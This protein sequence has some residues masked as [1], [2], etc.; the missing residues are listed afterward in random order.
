MFSFSLTMSVLRIPSHAGLVFFL[1]AATGI[2]GQ[3]ANQQQHLSSSDVQLLAQTTKQ[4]AY[5]Y[6]LAE[7]CTSKNRNGIQQYAAALGGWWARN[8]WK[9]LEAGPVKTELAPGEYDGLKAEATKE[10]NAHSFKSVFACG[11]IANVLKQP[12]H[13]PS[14]KYA[15]DLGRIAA[16]SAPAN[17]QQ[18][19]TPD[20]GAKASSN[21]SASATQNP[22]S[23]PP[24]NA[25]AGETSA[26]APPATQSSAP[27]QAQAPVI[28]NGSPLIV[29]D[30]SIT[31]T[32]GWSVSKSTPDQVTLQKTM[33]TKL[34]SSTGD[35]RLVV[36]L[37]MQPMQGGLDQSFAAA[38]RRNFPGP[39]LEL[40]YINKGVTRGGQQARVVRDGG[41]M[42]LPGN[43]R[44]RIRAVGIAAPDG[45]MLL[46]MIL[47]RSDWESLMSK[48]DDEFEAMIASLRFSSQPEST[49]WSF[50]RPQKGGG[51]QSGLYWANALI[52]MPNAFGGMDLRAERYY[53]ILM[54]DGRAYNDLPEDGHVQD[55]DINAACQKKPKKCGTY[56]ISGGSIQ[57]KWY[58]DYGLVE[59][60]QS[61]W[62]QGEKGSFN[63]RGHDY[64]RI[65]PVHGLRVNGKYTSTFASVGS[66]GT[67][68]TSVVSEKYITFT[69]D[70]RYQKSGFS[71][72][73]FD[74]SN[75]AGTFTSRKGVQAGTYSI[76]GYTLTLTPTGSAPELYS[77]IFED[78]TPSPKAI[79]INDDGFL[80]N[81]S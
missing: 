37:S 60:S 29:G 43:P 66:I 74:N 25:A 36:L 23:Q 19:A 22:S 50:D 58:D 31:P 38:V 72:G 57:F 16:A 13:D 61:P 49:L 70:G 65:L 11:A 27:H 75:A 30:A 46:A 6:S 64:R 45:R 44:A 56:Q 24:A 51:G 73:S 41:R 17:P 2:S 9:Q 8:H 1:C 47:M 35:A 67:Q 55:I 21:Q 34:R 7:W 5:A 32:A 48:A 68:S 76:D 69:P 4:A 3:E 20:A 52:N 40:K 39:P 26:G 77:V 63:T 80:R 10:L 28:A 59:E 71:G 53:V 81:G 78:P 42:N 79:F 15:E 62:V 12:E 14:L 33:V 18:T 54:P